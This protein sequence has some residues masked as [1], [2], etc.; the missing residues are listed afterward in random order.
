MSAALFLMDKIG[1]WLFPNSNVYMFYN[2]H[3]FLEWL[4]MYLESVNDTLGVC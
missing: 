3:W 2:P 1:V 4:T